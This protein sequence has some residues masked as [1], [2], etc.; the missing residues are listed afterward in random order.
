LKENRCLHWQVTR[1]FTPSESVNIGSRLPED[2]DGYPIAYDSRNR[3]WF[4]KIR[5]ERKFLVAILLG[6]PD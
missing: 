2:P 4:G 6:Q 1:L 5:Y 3:L